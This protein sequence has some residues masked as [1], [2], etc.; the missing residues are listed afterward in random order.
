MRGV[1]GQGS[2]RGTAGARLLLGIRRLGGI[3][4]TSGAGQSGFSPALGWLGGRVLVFLSQGE[5]IAEPEREG[6]LRRW[7][8]WPP[9]H[10]PTLVSD[11]CSSTWSHRR[12]SLC[13]QQA[14]L[15][16][17]LPLLRATSAGSLTSSCELHHSSP[18]RAAEPAELESG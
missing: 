15:A 7:A 9:G 17:A 4:S 1:P 6:A 14:A 10:P 2:H 11:L 16:H 8:S 12:L 18:G 5:E 13:P 3:L